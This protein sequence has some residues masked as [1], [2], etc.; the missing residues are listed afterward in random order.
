MLCLRTMGRLLET[1]R[2][3]LVAIVWLFFGG[4]TLV[5]ISGGAFSP[6]DLTLIGIAV[7]LHLVINWVLQKGELEEE[8]E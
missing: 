2:R 6:G 3:L 7:G 5:E 8:N 1:I 4:L